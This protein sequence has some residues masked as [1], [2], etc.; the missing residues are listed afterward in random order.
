MGSLSAVLTLLG[1]V[2][3]YTLVLI[4]AAQYVFVKRPSLSV[5]VYRFFFG[6]VHGPCLALVDGVDTRYLQVYASY[7]NWC[8]TALCSR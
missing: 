6:S 5:C 1:R 4:R 8:A 3:G 7:R 2:G